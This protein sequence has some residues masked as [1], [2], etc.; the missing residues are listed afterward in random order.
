MPT[1]P[2]DPQPTRYDSPT[3]ALHWATAALVIFQFAS[4]EF[5]DFFPKPAKHLLIIAHMSLGMLL[6]LV[7]I[8]RL[9]WRLTRGQPTRP[10]GNKVL[11]AAARAMHLALYTLL[12]IQMPLGIFTRWTDNHPLNVFGL[13]IPSPLAP[14]AKATGEFVD[15]LHDINAWVIIALAG[16]HAAIALIHHFIWRDDVLARMLPAAAPLKN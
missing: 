8:A 2:A 7:L 16:A 10:T 13:L 4:A 11:D 15:Q 6:L 12:A 9:A 5:W 1:P 3:I 14:C